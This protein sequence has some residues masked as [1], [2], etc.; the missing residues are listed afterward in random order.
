MNIFDMVRRWLDLRGGGGGPAQA[1]PGNQRTELPLTPSVEQE[2]DAELGF[3]FEMRVEELRSQGLSAEEAQARAIEEF[4][5]V[6]SVRRQLENIERRMRR[7][8]GSSMAASVALRETR[9]AGRALLRDPGFS[10]AAVLTLALGLGAAT[11]IFALLD[12]VVLRPLPYAQPDRLVRLQSFVPGV[13]PDVHWALSR[14]QYLHYRERSRSFEAMGL[15]QPGA[16]TIEGTDGGERIRTALVSAS[17]A[18]VIGARPLL[19][20]L[21][22]PDENLSER[23]EAAVLS[24]AYWRRR[25]GSS[26]DVIGTTISLDGWPFEIVGVLRPDARLPE[27]LQL[28]GAGTDV[29]IPLRLHPADRPQNH[30][31]FRGIARLESGATAASAEAELIALTHNFPEEMPS[32]YSDAFMEQ[33]G[34]RPK[35]LTLR[36]ELLGGIADRMWILFGSVLLVLA[37]AAA[38]VANLFMVRFEARRKE[39]VVRRALGANQRQ[40][41]WHSLGE[42]LLLA[43]V[44]C[45]A[46]LL[47]AR[48]AIVLIRALAPADVPRLVDADITSTALLFAIGVALAVGIIFGLVPLRHGGS[49]ADA[50][51]EDA[52]GMTSSKRS[53]RARG[54]L[55]ATQVALAVVLL[56]AAGLLTRSFQQFRDVQPGIDARGALTFSVHLPRSARFEDREAINAFYRTTVARLETMPGVERAGFATHLPLGGEYGCTGLIVRGRADTEETTGGCVP[57]VM[58]SPGYLESF[59]IPVRGSTLDWSEAPSGSL[60]VVVSRAFAQRFWPGEDPIGNQL[61]CCR[62]Q[63]PYHRVI[64]VAEDVLANGLDRPPAEIAYF[65][66]EDPDPG[67]VRPLSTN[68]VVRT[69]G[70]DPM[71]LVPAIR[72][73]IAEIE[74][75]AAVDGARAMEDVV[76]GSIARVRFTMVLLAIAAAMALL[77]SVVGVYGVIAYVTGQR[78]PEIGVRMV[79][80]ATG[81][82]V[83]WMVVWRTLRLAAVGVTLGLAGAFAAT[84]ALRSLLFEVS[85]IDPMVFGIAAAMLLLL[86]GVAGLFPA[87]R[88]ARLDPARVLQR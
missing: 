81:S 72:R 15:Y 80:G 38:N 29:W 33:S 53:E 18:E 23:P 1:P 45:G 71:S 42:S 14:G 60:G 27:D 74:P 66:I 51:R 65:P 19:G 4:G 49:A 9:R 62:A 5:E 76:A 24:H 64:G 47:L 88:A 39:T 34:F 50:L 46:A 16:A 61:R 32:A 21:M 78:R 7:R 48:G 82:Q 30:H 8:R 73:A 52:R 41:A 25:F 36:D 12:A 70:G 2:I 44:S 77:L 54:A 11:A 67:L 69:V 37:I 79:L 28:P 26:P 35:V 17:V 6:P 3:H 58:T 57:I 22:H 83:G 68:A 59:A 31:M 63:E 84:R 40:L 43:A 85:P 56:A 75:S 10:I 13:G 87:V 86:A 20:R 55:V